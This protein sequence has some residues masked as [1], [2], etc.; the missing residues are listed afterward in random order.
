MWLHSPM[1]E[2]QNRMGE[3]GRPSPVS[4][5]VPRHDIPRDGRSGFVSVEGRQVHYL[6]WGYGGLPNVLCLHGGGQ[7]SYMFEDLG[8][9][10]ACEFHVLAPDLPNHGDSDPLDDLFGAVP[11]AETILPL[12]DEFGL[13]RVVLV[14]ASLGGLI[15]TWLAAEHPD[16]A[17]GLVLIDV[18]HRLERDGVRRIVDFLAAHESFGSLEEAAD[19][20]ARFLPGRKQIRL[21]SLTRNL[22][23]RG[24][25]RWEWKHGFGGP[26]RQMSDEE[27]PAANLDSLLAPVVDAA[28][29]LA[30]PALVLRGA[31]SDVLSEQGAEDVAM[32]IPNARVETVE[33]AGHLA[34][35]DNPYS[36]LNHIRSFLD[37]LS[38]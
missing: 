34:A 13:D 12:L 26:L 27:H 17:I 32:L 23:Q 16:R 15:A 24:D 4:G 30:C 29:R 25:G 6:E 1:T 14:G 11:L 21:D 8:S 2:N 22:R 18:G 38:W 28:P 37:G 7:T 20:I 19:E 10:L 9:S 35:G 5:G 36:T 31:N 3:S 33:N